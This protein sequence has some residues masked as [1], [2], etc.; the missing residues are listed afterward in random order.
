MDLP[1]I[2]LRNGYPVPENVS[3][4]TR[5]GTLS[6]EQLFSVL[7][8][9]RSNLFHGMKDPDKD[10]RDLELSRKAAEFMVPFCYLLVEQTGPGQ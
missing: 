10:V 4:S 2:N 1:V 3:G 7:Y 6:P 8:Q 9:I 5:I